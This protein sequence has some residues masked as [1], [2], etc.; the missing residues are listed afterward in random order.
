MTVLVPRT[1]TEI[2]EDGSPVESEHPDDDSIDW[3]KLLAGDEPGVEPGCSFILEDFRETDAY[4]LLGA[5]GAGKTTV[6]E[7]EGERDGCH[8]VTARNFLAFG[9]CPA[10]RDTTLFIDGLDEM[11]AGLPGGCVRF[12]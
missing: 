7:A 11:R 5:P 3:H 6:F 1:C 8:C 2:G 12:S 4:V 9:D 10:W